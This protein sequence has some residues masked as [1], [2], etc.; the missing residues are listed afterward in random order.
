MFE[1][2]RNNLIY[3]I[4]EAKAPNI[5][6]AI[7]TIPSNN[8]SLDPCFLQPAIL[9]FDEKKCISCRDQ[10]I[11]FQ[12]RYNNECVQSCPKRTKI[13]L[14]NNYSCIDLHCQNYYNYNQT[15]CLEEIPKG[16]FLNDSDLKTIDKCNYYYSGKC[17][18]DCY[19][20]T[21]NNKLVCTDLFEP[22]FKEYLTFCFMQDLC[23][24]CYNDTGYYPFYNKSLLNSET[25]TECYKELDGYFL[26]YDYAYKPCFNTCKSCLNEGN[27]TNNN[28]TKC[29]DNYAFLNDS[30]NNVINCYEEC[31]ENYYYFDSS[32]KY[33]CTDECPNGY[34]LIKDKNQCI[35]NCSKDIEYHYEFNNSCLRECPEHHIEINNT[36]LKV[37]VS[38]IETDLNIINSNSAVNSNLN[39]IIINEK[40]ECPKDFPYKLQN[41][42]ECIKECNVTNIF[43]GIC[44]INNKDSTVKDDIINKIRTGLL[45]HTIDELLKDV[46]DGKKPELITVQENAIFALTTLDNQKN[47]ILKNESTIYLGECENKLKEHYKNININD[48]LLIFKI[49]IFEDGSE[50]PI[51]EYEIYNSKTKEKLDLIYCKDI[52]ILINIH[53][54]IDEENV[55]KYNPKSDFYKDICFAYT[56]EDGTDINLKDRKNEFFDKNLSICEANCDFEGYN[57][58][59]GK[60]I[61]ECNVKIKIPLMS[62]IVI[63]K[64]LLK[65]K[66]VDIKNYINLNVMK[67][68]NILFTSKGLLFNIG[69]YTIFAIIFLNIILLISFLSKGYKNLLNKIYEFK[70]GS[71][72]YKNK[73]IMNN[74]NIIK[75]TGNSKIKKGKKTNKKAYK[76]IIKKA[77]KKTIKKK[78]KNKN[79]KNNSDIKEPPKKFKNK[80]KTKKND[81][82]KAIKLSSSEVKVQLKISQK[83]INCKDSSLNNISILNSNNKQKK[84]NNNHNKIFIYYNDYEFN[85]LQYYE[86]LKADRRTYPQ[87]YFSLLRMR[88]LLVFT[89]F[90]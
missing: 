57:S 15:D 42:I 1:G 70:K 12:Y 11:S 9:L 58:E 23:I 68:Y 66:F 7:Q 59:L 82:S 85:E 74:N 22:N 21:N 71:Y 35:D 41:D 62:E 3:W 44:I 43:N 2:A 72:S 51:I 52:K 40:G 5:T 79:K 63:N 49:E 86:A 88:Y 67:Y 76:K 34:K 64:D 65:S 50:Y 16:Y 39:K 47:Y 37:Q 60:V 6:K 27:E 38:V 87:Y 61:C 8:N 10:N 29:K 31:K 13:N 81:D 46:I 45:N 14:Y 24:Y 48:P 25:F 28:C 20:D 18:S 73:G 36:C 77:I 30:Q 54:K 19:N 83:I 53:A 55:F 89:F 4:D 69:S 90:K 26:D 32:N 56:T 17:F 75:T 80:N 78:K 33:Q 84:K